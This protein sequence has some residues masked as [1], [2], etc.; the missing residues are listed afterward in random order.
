MATQ[1]C[2]DAEYIHIRAFREPDADHLYKG[3]TEI[4][5]YDMETRIELV[6]NLGWSCFETSF[7]CDTCAAKPYCGH[8]E[9]VDNG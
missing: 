1:C 4:D 7:E 8:F 3:K 9:E 5:W 2:E 6:K